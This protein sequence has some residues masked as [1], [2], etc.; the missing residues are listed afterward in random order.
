MNGRRKHA[1]GSPQT[2]HRPPSAPQ[3]SHSSQILARVSGRTWES[4]KGLGAGAVTSARG[5]TPEIAG[6]YLPV[7]IM[8]SRTGGPRLD[9]CCC[10]LANRTRALCTSGHYEPLPGCFL[11]LTAPARENPVSGRVRGGALRPAQRT[12]A[13]HDRKTYW[14]RAS[15]WFQISGSGERSK[16]KELTRRE[17]GEGREGEGTAVAEPQNAE[18]S[19]WSATSRAPPPIHEGSAFPPVPNHDRAP[20]LDKS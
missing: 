16:Q 10:Y 15:P 9:G 2:T 13:R 6:T 7:P 3:S 1:P 4:Q 18:E 8:V 17:G 5:A 12:L 20:D 11:H 19:P 14:G